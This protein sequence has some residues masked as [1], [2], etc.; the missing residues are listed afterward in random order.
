MDNDDALRRHHLALAHRLRDLRIEAGIS[1]HDMA[2]LLSW[3]QSRVS[4][5]ETAR[6][7][8]TAAELGEYASAVG[9]SKTLKKELLKELQELEGEWQS[10]RSL[11]QL[12]TQTRQVEIGETEDSS[13]TIRQVLLVTVPGLLQTP[14]YTRG[15]CV[16]SGR[17]ET[18]DDAEQAVEVRLERQEVLKDKTKHFTF[19]LME[20]ALSNRFASID[21]MVE[22]YE[23]LKDMSKRPNIRLGIVSRWTPLPFLLHSSFAIFDERLVTVDTSNG[24][25]VLR[26]RDDIREHS[27]LYE[28]ALSVSA[29]GA[30]ARQMLDQYI[31]SLT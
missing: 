27:T 30:D 12:G 25:L 14:D 4:R 31:D 16:A 2:A 28:K 13:A 22:Q 3:S 23:H 20:S 21:V 9:V 18:A 6:Q 10:F 17:F 8:P 7:M 1:G 11:Q 15:L 26:H 5:L 19:L 24:E 29:L